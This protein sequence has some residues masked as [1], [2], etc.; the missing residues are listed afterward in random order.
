MEKFEPIQRFTRKMPTNRFTPATGPGTMCGIF[1]ETNAKG[2]ASR[3]DPVRIGGRLKQTV[4][5]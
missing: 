4:P 3:I 1:V 5:A 2:L